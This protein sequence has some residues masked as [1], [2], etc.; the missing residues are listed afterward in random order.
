MGKQQ[1]KINH[2]CQPLCINAIH[3][4]VT[5]TSTVENDVA[6][7]DIPLLCLTG[8]V[9][10]PGQTLPLH[11]FS[12]N[13]AAMI[14]NVADDSG[15]F[16]VVTETFAS[17]R[18]GLVQ[19]TIGTTVEVTSVQEDSVTS[20]V[21]V[22]GVGGQR[23]RVISSRRQTDGITVGS[24]KMV[25]DK[26]M[27]SPFQGILLSCQKRRCISSPTFQNASSAPDNSR[28]AREI[29][30]RQSLR[31]KKL[32]RFTAADLTHWPSWVY[33]Q[34]DAKSV[35]AKIGD[36][37][38]AC[39]STLNASGRSK[40]ALDYSFWLMANLPMDD[41][42][43]LSLLAMNNTI[44]RL[45]AE[46]LILKSCTVICCKDCGLLIADKKDVF[47]MAAKDGPLGMYV[48]PGGYIHEMITVYKVEGLKLVGGQ[49]TENTWFSGFAWT[50]VQCKNCAAHVGWKF[51]ATSKGQGQSPEKFWGLC[52]S[53]VLPGI[54]QEPSLGTQLFHLTL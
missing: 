27:S 31:R 1:S 11:L 51:A 16:G 14:R 26:E 36:E 34:Y 30:R 35:M 38:D 46:L 54:R 2:F 13:Q 24:I 12:P 29:V 6:P 47:S 49:S 52:R 17:A 37:L 42:L 48:N 28:N 9:L 53:S 22:Q 8:V 39:N 21:K 20:S 19:S 41:Q 15:V 18:D 44:E 33:K 4:D 7:R 40:G 25:Y 5:K 3:E 10:V 45:R 32:D 43:K 50:V 23:F